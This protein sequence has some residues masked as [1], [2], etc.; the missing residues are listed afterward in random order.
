MQNSSYH[1]LPTRTSWKEF[2]C[3]GGVL[4]NSFIF[5]CVFICLQ[6]L[7]LYLWT[8]LL[9]TIFLIK[10]LFL[11]V[12]FLVLVL[13]FWFL[14]SITYILS[15]FFLAYKVSVEKFIIMELSLYVM[16]CSFLTGFKILFVKKKKIL[17]LTFE[18]LIIMCLNATL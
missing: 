4:V 5:L 8:A 18:N 17:S 12:V 10:R 6:I 7:K 3:F 11:V 15:Y 14:F 13:G 2:W 1:F 9:C 16:S